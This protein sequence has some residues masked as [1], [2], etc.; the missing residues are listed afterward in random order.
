QWVKSHKILAVLATTLFVVGAC[1]AA[2]L[3]TPAKEIALIIGEPWKDM[4][5][6]STAEIGPV[7][8]DSNWYRQPRLL[9]RIHLMRTP[10]HH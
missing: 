7:F 3:L 1:K 4:Q 6:R 5:V 10:L 9:S 2:E 8:K